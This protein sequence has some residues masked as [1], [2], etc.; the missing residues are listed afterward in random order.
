MPNPNA[1][2]ILDATAAHFQA[3][4]ANAVA[5]VNSIL[6]EPQPNAEAA[7]QELTKRIK[8]IALAE[9][10]KKIILHIQGAKGTASQEPPEVP[11]APQPPATAEVPPTNAE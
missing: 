1:K 9:Q 11:P 7:I 5:I 8:D 4:D 10:A 2:Y 3:L 6:N